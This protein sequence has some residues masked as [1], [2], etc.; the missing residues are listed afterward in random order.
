MASIP[1]AVVGPGKLSMIHRMAFR[2]RNLV[3]IYYLEPTSRFISVEWLYEIAGCGIAYLMLV[4]GSGHTFPLWSRLQWAHI[5]YSRTL[6][7]NR[8]TGLIDL[9]IFVLFVCR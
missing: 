3:S 4:I 6:F 5:I 2:N 9:V 8:S 1:S 7:K